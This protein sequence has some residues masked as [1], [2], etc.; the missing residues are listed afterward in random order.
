MDEDN[1]ALNTMRR[2]GP[3][4]KVNLNVAG[5]KYQ[6]ERK[7]TVSGPAAAVKRKHLKK[8]SEVQN[9]GM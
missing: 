8:I 7:P 4:G 6:T 1:E 2:P 3:L 9:A 5:G